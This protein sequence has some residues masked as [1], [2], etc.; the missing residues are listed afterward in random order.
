MNYI[1][2]DWGALSC[3]SIELEQIRAHGSV[4]SKHEFCVFL[5]SLLI[6]FQMTKAQHFEGLVLFICKPPY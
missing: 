2:V 5:I 3:C 6:L 4:G 1:C